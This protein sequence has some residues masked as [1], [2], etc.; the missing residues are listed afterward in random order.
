VVGG[1]GNDGLADEGA[2]SV[3]ADIM[4]HGGGAPGTPFCQ[5]IV[6]DPRPTSNDVEATAPTTGGCK[7][8]MLTTA[9]PTPVLI[10]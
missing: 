8:A 6:D 5:V 3:G 2:T 1:G 7:T 9:W 4:A 10:G